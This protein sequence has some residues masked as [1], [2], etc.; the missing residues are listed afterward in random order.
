[1]SQSIIIKAKNSSTSS[2][3]IDKS[4]NIVVWDIIWVIGISSRLVWDHDKHFNNWNWM[5]E[6]MPYKRQASHHCQ[7][8]PEAINMSQ[9]PPSRDKIF[10]ITSTRIKIL[11]YL[12]NKS[13]FVNKHQP[14]NPKEYPYEKKPWYSPLIHIC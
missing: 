14:T 8:V 10:P 5:K 13:I 9:A 1:M 12:K 6:W 11:H 3:K 4:C 7:L 2:I